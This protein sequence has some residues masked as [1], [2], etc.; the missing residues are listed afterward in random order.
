[1]TAAM[2]HPLISD[3]V[4]RLNAAAATLPP[5]QRAELVADIEAHLR[6]AMAHDR[7]SEAD[8]R[9]VL[10]RLGSP[11]EL[12]AEA[13]GASPVVDAAGAPQAIPMASHRSRNREVAALVLFALTGVLTISLIGAPIAVL[14]W[15]PAVVL[16]LVSS[17]WS[18]RE[19]LAGGLVLGLVGSPMLLVGAGLA[20]AMFFPAEVCA[21]WPDEIDIATGAVIRP[22][23]AEC[24]GGAPSWLPW[25]A[26]AVVLIVVALWL[27]TWV[28]LWRS[29]RRAAP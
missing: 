6:D 8:L 4:A 12:V 18:P 22:G 24:T 21:S 9:A 15:I 7:A 10:D 25:L 2:N 27:L 23:R 28:R 17:V 19:K 29:A 16:L 1:M 20:P 5:D 11:E 14:T 13:G 3:Y 26:G